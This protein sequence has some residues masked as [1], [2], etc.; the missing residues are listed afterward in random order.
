MPTILASALKNFGPKLDPS[1]LSLKTA[2]QAADLM[3][4]EFLVRS[5]Q[6]TFDLYAQWRECPERYTDMHDTMC[7]KCLSATREHNCLVEEIHAEY[8]AEMESFW[9]EFRESREALYWQREEAKMR[10]V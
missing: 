6:V 10:Y 8:C 2:N 4:L 3:Y 9:T 7:I 1:T 5:E